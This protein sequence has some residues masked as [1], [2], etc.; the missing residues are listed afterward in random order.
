MFVAERRFVLLG[1][2]DAGGRVWATMLHGEPGFLS[3]PADD[4]LRI[5]ARAPSGDPLEARSPRE[6]DVGC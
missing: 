4:R 6:A 3:V 5:D 2:A 1:A